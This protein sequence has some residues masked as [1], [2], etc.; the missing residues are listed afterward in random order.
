MVADI[1]DGSVNQELSDIVSDSASDLI[2]VD[3]YANLSTLT[4]QIAARIC[5]D[6]VRDDTSLRRAMVLCNTPHS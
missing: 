4:G 2:P 6:T 3:S 5:K 1:G